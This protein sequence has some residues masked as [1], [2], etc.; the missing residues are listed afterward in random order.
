MRRLLFILMMI[1]ELELGGC[2]RCGLPRSTPSFVPGACSGRLD[3]PAAAGRRRCPT[4]ATHRSMGHRRCQFGPAAMLVQIRPQVEQQ[5][6]EFR[7]AATGRLTFG[8]QPAS[9]AV[10]TGI[11]PS[12]VRSI[13]RV[14]AMSNG[15]LTFVAFASESTRRSLSERQS[16]CSTDRAQLPARLGYVTVAGER[17]RC[18]RSGGF[19]DA[20]SML[21]LVPPAPSY[22]ADA[23]DDIMRQAEAEFDVGHGVEAIVLWKQALVMYRSAD[24]VA[25][26]LGVLHRLG[27]TSQLI[28]ERQ[29][30]VLHLSEAV[31][32]A[33]RTGN[34]AAEAGLLPKL[35][36]AAASKAGDLPL[37]IAPTARCSTAWG[38]LG[39]PGARSRAA[40]RLGEALLEA[41][42]SR[43]AVPAFPCRRYPIRVARSTQRR[44]PR[45][46]LS[47]QRFV[48]GRAVCCGGGP[49][50]AGH[51]HRTGE[52]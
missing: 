48:E 17:R 2:R 30:A 14:V 28:G 12:G 42:R 18:T 52:P 38:R 36:E 1:G 11:P 4:A 10:Y 20:F 35:A 29:D 9:Y 22:G 15:R 44:G 8:G 16:Q 51:S 23:P 50:P 43:E 5:W 33:R 13:Q 19:W 34:T 3:S 21:V 40:A 45:I 7:E 24:N 6:K 39:D 49:L 26:Q 37:A 27:T 32:L 25:G 31:D 41:G 47:R 46:L